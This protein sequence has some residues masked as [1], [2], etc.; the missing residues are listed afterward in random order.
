MLSR[1]DTVVPHRD[2]GNVPGMY[3]S[4]SMRRCQRSGILNNPFGKAASYVGLG[5][6][7]HQD[8]TL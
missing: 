1:I 4:A 5:K 3:A 2:I 6:S 8:V 7:A